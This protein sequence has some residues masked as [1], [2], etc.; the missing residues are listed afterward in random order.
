MRLFPV[1]WFG[2]ILLTTMPLHAA[3]AAEGENP[4]VLTVLERTTEP[5]LK[6]NRPWED[7]GVG[8]CQVLK[9]GDQ[10]HLW[11]SSYDDQYKD[12]NDSYLCYARS[13]DGVHWEK[14][15]L[16]VY[17]YRGSTNKRP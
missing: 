9:I 4:L 13:G 10:W 8:Y 17:S 3:T 2:G 5:L 16:G 6:A 12:D 15:S 7:R 14:P 11:Y 1:I